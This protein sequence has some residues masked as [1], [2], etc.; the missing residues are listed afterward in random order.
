MSDFLDVAESLYKNGQVGNAGDAFELVF[1]AIAALQEVH[2]K[3][4]VNL[5]NVESV[6]AAFEMGKLLGRFGDLTAEQIEKLPNAMRRVIEATIEATVKFPVL[7]DKMQPPHPYA[8]LAKLVGEAIPR[9]ERTLS[10]VDRFS[11]ISFN[12]DLC[13]DF[14]FHFF[15]IPIGYRLGVFKE[16][17]SLALLKLHGSLNWG[18]CKSCQQTVAWPLSS[19]FLNRR[20][21]LEM[22]SEV[23]LRVG[24][25][26]HEFRHCEKGEVEGPYLVPPT[27]NK[28]Q[29]HESLERVWQAAAKELATAENIFICGYSLPQTDEFFKY[30]YALGTIGPARLKR[31][32]VFNPDRGVEENFR[33]LL[34]QAVLSRFTF[35][36]LKFEEMFAEVRPVFGLTNT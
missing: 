2:S 10:N 25:K 23:T 32:W 27:W 24:S 4:A 9:T 17:E 13:T 22:R 33:R 3:A 5:D 6:F 36:P 34:G 1:N 35:F 11:L 7:R 29:Y 28:A 12:Y 16:K 21:A 31:F 30:L 20:F 14:A 26:M 15:G 19:F 8:E 18:R